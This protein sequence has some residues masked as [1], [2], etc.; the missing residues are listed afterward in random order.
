MNKIKINVGRVKAALAAKG[1]NH[2]EAAQRL[3]IGRPGFER[4]LREGR[5]TAYMLGRIAHVLEIPTW[6]LV[7]K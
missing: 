1:L 5:C 2:E 6:E 3:G 4:I 7:D